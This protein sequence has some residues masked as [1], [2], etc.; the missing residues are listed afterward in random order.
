MLFN[1]DLLQFVWK[2]KLFFRPDLYTQS[3]QELKVL[4]VGQHNKNAGPDFEHARLLI[5]NTQWSGQVEVHKKA[6]EWYLHKHHLDKAYNNVVLHVVYEADRQVCRQDGTIVE[7]LELKA[8]LSPSVL[9][10]Y[11]QLSQSKSWIP[12]ASQIGQIDGFRLR[13]WLSRVLVERLENKSAY[14]LQLVDDFHGD[15]NEVAYVALARNFGFKVNAFPFELLAKS[16]PYKILQ[17][18]RDSTRAVEALLFGQAGLLVGEMV[19]DDA[20]VSAIV[21]EYR[22]LSKQYALRPIDAVAWKFLRMR[23]ANF[24]TIR[25]AQFSSLCMSVPSLFSAMV[26]EGE[27]TFMEKLRKIAVSPYWKNHYVFSKEARGH[28]GRFGESSIHNIL[29][30]TVA[31]LLFAYGKYVD[32]ESY[33]CRAVSLLESLLAEK[34]NVISQFEVLGVKAKEAA[35][36]QSLLQLK[37]AYC[38]RRKCLECGLGFELFKSNTTL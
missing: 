23:P 32:K 9:A 26:D 7:T 17:K 6:S 1:E 38:D 25:I 12:C 29:I 8:I 24:P 2:Y 27:S 3:G 31:I 10:Q 19:E 35:D 4:A 36:S 18:H 15:W 11:R 21:K 30:N 22:F 33:I 5:G 34:N 13:Q 20:Y 37:S 14:I 28:S 16:V